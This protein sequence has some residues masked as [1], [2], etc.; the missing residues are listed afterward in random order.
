MNN[1]NM[2]PRAR[3]LAV[4]IALLALA[5]LATGCDAGTFLGGMMGG[6]GGMMGWI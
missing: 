3:K 2:I 6:L 4:I 1:A 5:A